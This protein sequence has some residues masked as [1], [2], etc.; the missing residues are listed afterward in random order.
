MN[1]SYYV[2]EDAIIFCTRRDTKKFTQIVKRPGVA[3]LIHDFPHLQDANDQNHGKS[4][5]VT[6]NG[7][8]E[9]HRKLIVN[10]FLRILD[11]Q[12]FSS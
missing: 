6:L 7:K 11:G 5:S 12:N 10:D 2:P 4:W 8:C 1:F 3:V 9:V